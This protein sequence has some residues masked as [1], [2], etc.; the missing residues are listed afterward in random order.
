MLIF[1]HENPAA[2]E[3]ERNIF[4][5][6][7]IHTLCLSPPKPAD[8]ALYP[9]RGFLI[10]RPEDISDLESICLQIN[11]LFP[12]IPLAIFYREG[13]GNP[14]LYQRMCDF[15]FDQN[16]TSTDIVS[17]MYSLYKERTGKETDSLLIGNIRTV[18]RDPRLFLFGHPL[19]VTALQWRIV[20]YL[21]LTHPRPVP[22]Q[23]IL[24]TCFSFRH[25]P[26]ANNVS[27]QISLLN[28]RIRHLFSFTPISFC[29]ERGYILSPYRISEKDS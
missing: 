26:A 19:P 9:I 20:R 13:R 27:T 11:I 21:Q 7:R 25:P 2:V 14:Y 17:R 18:L 22:A 5:R 1:L 24:D 12:D 28:K 3:A 15:V 6:M 29:S 16:T 10:P 4:Y 8:A 23:E